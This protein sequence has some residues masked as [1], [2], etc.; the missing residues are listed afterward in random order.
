MYVCAVYVQEWVQVCRSVCT[1]RP[2]EG[3]KH[4]AVT[5][6]FIPWRQG[7]HEHRGKLTVSN[8]PTILL[9][10]LHSAGVIGMHTPIIDFS[11]GCW[12]L[13]LRSSCLYS[14]HFSPLSFPTPS[15]VS[16]KLAWILHHLV[17]LIMMTYKTL[18]LVC[19]V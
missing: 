13:E 7:L 14:N 2:E 4:L 12:G 19:E 17:Y 3:I 16:L 1:Q 5:S 6:Y 11:R 18:G 15:P 8:P 9:S 10:Q